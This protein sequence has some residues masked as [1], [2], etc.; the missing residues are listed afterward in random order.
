MFDKSVLDIFHVFSCPSN[1]ETA[2]R[3]Y[4]DGYQ[5]FKMFFL[6]Y[7]SSKSEKTVGLFNKII[8]F[9]N[10]IPPRAVD[11]YGFL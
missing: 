3:D 9:Y 6:W 10:T 4:V 7:E 5:V 11:S 2:V 1:L 8:S